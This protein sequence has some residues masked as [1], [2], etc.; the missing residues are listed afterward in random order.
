[1][2]PHLEGTGR[3]VAPGAHAVVALDGAGRHGAPRLATPG[4]LTLPPLPAYAPEPNPVENVWECLRQNEPG[5]RVWDG[6]DALVESWLLRGAERAHARARPRRLHHPSRVGESG[7]QLRP[8]V[9][10]LAR[11]GVGGDVGACDL[12]LPAS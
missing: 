2:R 7:Q 4:D 8:L 6:C 5:H 12:A 1:M 9:S 11:P 10:P 3:H